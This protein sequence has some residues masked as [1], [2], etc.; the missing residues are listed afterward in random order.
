MPAGDA[1]GLGREVCHLQPRSLS[2]VGQLG[3]QESKGRNSLSSTFLQ[4][5]IH[6]WLCPG[7][8][9]FSLLSLPC[10]SASPKST[11]ITWVPYAPLPGPLPTSSYKALLSC[12]HFV[13]NMSNR[14]PPQILTF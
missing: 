11:P 14:N 9:V 10:R 6:P 1:E 13:S 2:G 8:L 7:P 4:G 5:P 3:P 12:F